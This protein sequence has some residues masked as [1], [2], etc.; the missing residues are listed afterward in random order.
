MTRSRSAIALVAVVALL[1]SQAVKAD[2]RSE[3]K[4]KFQLAGMLGKMVNFFG[5]KAA[6][7]GVTATVAVKGDRMVT[8]SD[9]TGQ[10]ID[11]A[12]EKIYDLDLKKKT[13]RVM[14]FADIRRQMEEAKKRAEEE[15]KKAQA[16]EPAAAPPEKDPNAKELE[17]DFEVKNTGQ[18]K[19]INGFDTEQAVMIITVREKG[20]TLEQ[21][22][23]LVMNSDIWLTPSIPA[24]KEVADFNLKY[25]QKLYGPMITGASPQ[26][27]AA[28][29]ALYPMMKPAIEKMAAEGSKLQGTPVLTV[30]TVD[31]VKSAEQIT[32][33]QKEASSSSSGSGGST[34][35]TVG[36]LIGGIGRRM[37]QR[38]ASEPAGPQARAN[39]MTTT[40]EVVKVATTVTAEEMAIPAGFKE[41]R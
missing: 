20:K 33:E 22:G 36:G 15:A 29:M 19:A 9:Q 38:R 31:A 5:G 21:S 1:S 40:F 26:D 35:S 16:E 8:T 12:E 17:I 2:V 6:R 18:K 11:L 32:A 34:P 13:Y 10:I 39:I 23:G 37:A 4:T 27:M 30:T 7:E 24:M 41:S 3:Q 14:T 28:A 25:A